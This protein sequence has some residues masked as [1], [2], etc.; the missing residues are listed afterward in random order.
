[1]VAKYCNRTNILK[2]PQPIGKEE[3]QT[4]EAYIENQLSYSQN[5]MSS[6]DYRRL[7]RPLYSLL[8]SVGVILKLFLVFF[9][10]LISLTLFMKFCVNLLYLFY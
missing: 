9:D 10:L 6:L 5:W 4:R 3:Y 2:Y 1:M 8:S 7:Q